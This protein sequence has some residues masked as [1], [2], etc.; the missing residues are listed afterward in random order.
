M[1]KETQWSKT[2]KNVISLTEAL[3]QRIRKMDD[4]KFKK[5]FQ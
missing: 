3:T 4:E 5:E 2:Y 1:T